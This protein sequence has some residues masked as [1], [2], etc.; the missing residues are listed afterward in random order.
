MKRWMKRIGIICLNTG[1]VGHLDFNSFVYTSL[2]EF[3]CAVQP[4]NM[5]VK[6]P[7]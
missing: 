4:P 1:G 5:P 3:R 2:P 7:V 6:Q